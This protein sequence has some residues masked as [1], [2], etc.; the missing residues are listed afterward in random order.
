MKSIWLGMVVCGLAII[1]AP[2]VIAQQTNGI[3]Q[4]T[5]SDA[6]GAVIT[7]ATITVVN[8]STQSTR[9]ETTGTDGSFA[10]TELLPGHYHVSATKEGFKT[11]NQKDIELHVASTVVLNV[12]LAVGTASEMVTVE[13]N[14]LE[15]ETTSGTLGDV[16]ESAKLKNYL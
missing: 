13:A 12:K 2:A 10:F 8:D 4:G 6:G 5:I 11:E 14:P 16:L 7:G 3:I 9:N 1:L 15:V